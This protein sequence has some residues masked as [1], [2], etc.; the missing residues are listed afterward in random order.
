MSEPFELT[1]Q[2]CEDLLGYL[3]GYANILEKYDITL[4]ELE[5]AALNK[6]IECCEHCGIWVESWDLFNDEEQIDGHC[7][8][9]R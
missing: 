7:N 5:D 4:E 1:D 3:F 8:N 6:N 9:C 2:D